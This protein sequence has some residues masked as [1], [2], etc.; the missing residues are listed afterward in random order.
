MIKRL[1]IIGVYLAVCLGNLSGQET[2]LFSQYMMNGFLYNPAIAGSDGYTSF[3]LTSRRQWL[4]IKDA[5]LTNSFTFQSR[6]LH[7]SYMIQRDPIRQKNSFI[8]SRS[9]RVGLGGAIISDRAGAFNRTGVQFTY[10]YHIFINNAQLSM[11]LTGNLYQLKYDF[12]QAMFSDPNTVATLINQLNKPYYVPDFNFGAYYLT[13]NY[14]VGISAENILQSAIKIGNTEVKESKLLRTYYFTGAYQ[15]KSAGDIRFEPSILAKF[16]EK[17][18]YE[19]DLSCKAILREMYWLGLSFRTN[20][21]IIALM[22]MRFNNLYFGYA[23]DYSFNTL[24]S[25]TYGS[26]ELMIA[27]KFGDN[28]RR[29]KW[30]IRY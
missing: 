15:F 30:I 24:T 9:G 17:N 6:I 11:G 12:T 4:G 16:N 19:A 20:K 1:C 14:H 13:E 21:E 3:N 27:M 8:P 23:F 7:R 2:P 5:P 10:A 25:Y 28:A 18:A 29:Y 26:H 22:G